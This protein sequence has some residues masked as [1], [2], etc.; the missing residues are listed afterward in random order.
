[1]YTMGRLVY[2]A[3]LTAT[4]ALMPACGPKAKSSG[5]AS[6]A[7]AAAPSSSNPPWAQQPED[8]GAHIP[9]N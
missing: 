5:G 4:L 8:S 6:P 9:Q 3:F 2:A 1:M 7:P